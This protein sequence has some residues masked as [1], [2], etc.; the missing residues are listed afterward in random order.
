MFGLEGR[1]TIGIC[2]F[3]AASRFTSP[4]HHFQEYVTLDNS[5]TLFESVSPF[6]KL[7]E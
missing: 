7:E 3:E 1:K 5:F 4:V 2:S 6:L